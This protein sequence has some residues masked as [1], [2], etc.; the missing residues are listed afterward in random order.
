MRD[1]LL[2]AEPLPAEVDGNL[3]DQG[4]GLAPAWQSQGRAQSHSAPQTQ[5]TRHA[6]ANVRE[7]LAGATANAVERGDKISSLADSSRRLA[8]NADQ[9]LDLAKQLNAQQNRWF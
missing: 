2:P 8:D 5:T 7:A 4:R 3:L 6:A 9:F 1:C